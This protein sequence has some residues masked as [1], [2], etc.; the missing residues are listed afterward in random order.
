MNLS[1]GW[2]QKLHYYRIFPCNFPSLPFQAILITLI[3][4]L[5]TEMADKLNFF[6]PTNGM[7]EYY[8]PQEIVSIRHLDYVKN[9]SVSQIIYD[10]AYDEA[11]PKSTQQGSHYTWPIYYQQGGHNFYNLSTRDCISWQ[12]VTVIPMTT[13]VIEAIQH[14]AEADGMTSFVLQY[15]NGF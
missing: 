1:R 5:A 10:Q 9:C 12:T 11:K 2:M 14:L 3:K 6:P 7:S 4:H 15:R 8:S 13:A